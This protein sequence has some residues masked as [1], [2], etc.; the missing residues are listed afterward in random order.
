MSNRGWSFGA[1]L[2]RF[3]EWTYFVISFPRDIDS[4]AKHKDISVEFPENMSTQ[5][6]FIEDQ[7][8]IPFV[9]TSFLVISI[10]WIIL[11]KQCYPVLTLVVGATF[12][13]MQFIHLANFMLSHFKAL[14]HRLHLHGFGK[15]GVS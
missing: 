1:V 2:D 11:V 10:W 3:M 15:A 4:Y 7:F 14:T 12:W 8:H 6:Q 5:Y 13:E 9:N